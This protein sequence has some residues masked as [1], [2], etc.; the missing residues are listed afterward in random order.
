MSLFLS[1]LRELIRRGIVP[2]E[3]MTWSSLVMMF[4][5]RLLGEKP[6]PNLNI[7]R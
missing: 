6:F 7:T 4:S 3:A 2:G 1:L 5:A